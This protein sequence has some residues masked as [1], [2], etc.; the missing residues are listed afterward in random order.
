[1]DSRG[2]DRVD[3][4]KRRQGKDKGRARGIG[5]KKR[6]RT[7]GRGSCSK[8]LRRTDAP[9]W[10]ITKSPK[11]CSVYVH[12]ILRMFQIAYS[13]GNKKPSCR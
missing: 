2:V 11:A 4:R 13:G 1:M 12:R 10:P 9:D 8:V 5:G 3:V 7:S 6:G